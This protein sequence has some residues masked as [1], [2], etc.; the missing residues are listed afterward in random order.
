MRTP[1]VSHSPPGNRD[2]DLAVRRL[3]LEHVIK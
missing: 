1:R 2:V 3:I